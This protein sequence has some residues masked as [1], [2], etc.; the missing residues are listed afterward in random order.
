MDI[1]NMIGYCFN[2]YYCLCWKYIF[3][4]IIGVSSLLYC[5]VLYYVICFVYD[6]V[7]ISLVFV[8]NGELVWNFVLFYKFSLEWI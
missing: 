2:M 6:L 3:F 7:L 1:E 8:C 4:F 5:F